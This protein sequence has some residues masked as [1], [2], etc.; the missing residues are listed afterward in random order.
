MVFGLQK[1]I[2]AEKYKLLDKLRNDYTTACNICIHCETPYDRIQAIAARDKAYK[3]YKEA[4]FDYVAYSHSIFIQ[5]DEPLSNEET[6]A[7]LDDE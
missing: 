7:L 4:A 3:A 5:D 1:T 6:W 2:L